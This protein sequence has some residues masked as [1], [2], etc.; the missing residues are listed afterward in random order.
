MFGF[1]LNPENVRHLVFGHLSLANFKR[2]LKQEIKATLFE[3]P[4]PLLKKIEAEGEK[5]KEKNQHLVKDAPSAGHLEFAS[6]VL[7]AYRILL[8]RLGL[9]EATLFFVKSATLRGMNNFSLRN[10][11]KA[12]IRACRRNPHRLYQAFGWMMQQYGTT[13]DWSVPH[14]H[15]DEKCQWNFKIQRC[16]YFDFFKAAGAP[17]LTTALCQIDALWFNQI[18]P[19]REGF[20]FDTSDY[21]TQGYGAE[22]CNFPIKQNGSGAQNSR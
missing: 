1:K 8:P 2:G 20:Y 11:L 17:R 14:A 21:R 6:H 3:K 5:I 22:S 4:G 18:K 10:G 19:E 7:G 9:E 13:F 12:L 15:E 16:F